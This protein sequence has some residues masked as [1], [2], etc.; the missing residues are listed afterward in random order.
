M[1]II[2]RKAHLLL[3]GLLLAC[4]LFC[5][6]PQARAAAQ[7]EIV[8]KNTTFY[9]DRTVAGDFRVT[10]GTL[11]LS[12]KNMTVS[13]NFYLEDGTVKLNGATLNILGDLYVSSDLDVLHG[14]VNVRG[15]VI[16]SAGTI[17]LGM[18]S[19]TAGSDYF[20]ATPKTNP[21]G[22][23][24]W[25]KSRGEIVM[26]YPSDTLTIG[27]DFYMDA[28]YGT[29][30]KAGTMA[31]A[32]N[33]IQMSDYGPQKFHASNTHKMI[34]NGTEPQIITIENPGTT[35]ARVEVTN[36]Q[37]LI[38]SD[39]FAAAELTAQ[40]GQVSIYSDGGTFRDVSLNV[41]QVSVTGDLT[42]NGDLKLNYNKL[43]VDGDLIHTD[44][45]LDMGWG[46]L[47]IGG[48]YYLAI[49]EYTEEGEI[50]WKGSH[51]ALTMQYP[52]ATMNIARDFYMNAAD[53]LF[54]TAGKLTVS[55]NFTQA[56]DYT[57]KKFFASNNHQVIF[58]G[59]ETQ[60][61]TLQNPNS[62]FATLTVDNAEG[63]R[64][65]NY[66]SAWKLNASSGSVKLL[67]EGA[68]LKDV[69]L[70]SCTSVIGDVTQ[71]GDLNLGHQTMRVHGNLTHTRGDVDISTG[72]LMVEGDYYIATP[73][74]DENG[75][76]TWTSSYGKLI[77]KFPNATLMVG[78]NFYADSVVISECTS[79]KLGIG[80]DFTEVAHPEITPEI[81]PVKPDVQNPTQNIN[82][83]AIFESSL[84]GRI[85]N[86]GIQV[87][88]SAAG[89][90]YHDTPYC[91][92]APQAQRVTYEQARAAWY[93]PC[94]K[95]YNP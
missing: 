64:V 84:F 91:R 78:G 58:N 1:N 26:R 45:I 21:L 90:Y 94:D 73:N 87:W 60:T 67:S 77:M 62:T 44:G 70:D 33:F 63:I 80:G 14:K 29:S 7:V 42:L 12:R 85:H 76:T 5:T 81:E 88:V 47:D 57:P 74:T 75:E 69:N 68:V 9:T 86:S 72:K 92:Y 93:T 79:G 46:V 38:I 40:S 31:L 13:G 3:A 41:R 2:R 30:F 52:R 50:Q 71:D 66:L 11:N 8:D 36:P 25:D 37:G 51:G 15:R 34:F 54:L 39:Y 55:G 4:G 61:I 56:V 18:G 48:S 49:P 19:L 10:G 6:A 82:V 16:H 22:E 53:S 83:V 20:L 32:G 89:P 23:L 28:S 35:F 17:D 95:C 27:G 59:K 43:S 65:T 24:I